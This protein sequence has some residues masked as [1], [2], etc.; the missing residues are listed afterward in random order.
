[1][2]DAKL[3]ELER[4]WRETGSVDDEAAYLSERVRTGDLRREHLELAA[5]CGSE[6][7]RQ[8]VGPGV[9]GVMSEADLAALQGS[10]LTS[11]PLQLSARDV[12]LLNVVE[13]LVRRRV[14][15]LALEIGLRSL[16]ALHDL[17]PVTDGAREALT[18]VN[19]WLAAP[20]P[21]TAEAA[22]FAAQTAADESDALPRR[23]D[24]DGSAI[25][26][27]GFLA[28]AVRHPEM[29]TRAIWTAIDAA[30]Q[31]GHADRWVREALSRTCSLLTTS[32]AGAT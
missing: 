29:V 8:V 1:M 21:E 28:E 5:L 25:A 14:V 2:S 7:A 10:F 4:R 16:R 13:C 20:S 27:A 19:E 32:R 12:A 15:S 23:Q 22:A 9:Q 18:A 11:N 17:V 3:R 26:A 31:A 24:N 30:Q 6:A